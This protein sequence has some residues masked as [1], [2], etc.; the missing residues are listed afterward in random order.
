MSEQQQSK[1]APVA[2]TALGTL[3]TGTAAAIATG[4]GGVGIALAGTAIGVSPLRS[5]SR[6]LG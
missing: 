1:R 5:P 3:A 4:G 2:A 6:S